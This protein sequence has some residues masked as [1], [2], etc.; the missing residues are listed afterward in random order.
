MQVPLATHLTWSD[1]VTGKANVKPSFLAARLLLVRARLESNG[2]PA[3]VGKLATELRELFAQNPDSP[4]V[5]H[6]L[7]MIFG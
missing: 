1:L 2:N 4:A 7:K 5:Q 6:D 3:C